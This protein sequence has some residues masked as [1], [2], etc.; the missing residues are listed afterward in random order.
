MAPLFKYS[1]D[2]LGQRI[3]SEETVNGKIKNTQYLMS[4]MLEQ[5][6]ITDGNVHFHTLGLD[7]SGSLVATGGVG[8]VL[9]SSEYKTENSKS[10]TFDYLFDGNGNVIATCDFTGKITAKLAYSPFGE[11]ISGTDLPFTFSTKSS[12][13]SGLV[14]Y[15][16]RLY[17]PKLG[18]WLTRDPIEERG[19][20]NM[21]S[22]ARNNALNNLDIIGLISIITSDS[23]DNEVN[24]IIDTSGGN[25]GCEVNTI[26]LVYRDGAWKTDTMG[27]NGAP[28]ADDPFYMDKNDPLYEAWMRCIAKI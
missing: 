25:G 13:A 17:N 9:A 23:K 11:K 20:D 10:E 21:Y 2:P 7:L 18:R 5:A 6:R 16:F 1:Y 14:Y 8:A 19:G 12:D 15:G 22:L 28:I 26:Q 24:V 3:K 27:V 4:G